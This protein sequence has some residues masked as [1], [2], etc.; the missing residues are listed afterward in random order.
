MA[1]IT[2]E[3]TI[4]WERKT[5]THYKN[6]GYPFTKIKD[7]FVVKVE[8]LM[9]NSIVQIEVQCDECGEIISTSWRNYKKNINRNIKYYCNKCAN[10]IFER[11]E[12][13]RQANFKKENSFET[14]CIEN[15]RRD[16][17]DR[18]DYELNN[19]KP[20]EISYGTNKKYYF[21]CHKILGH[22]SELKN[23]KGFI[24]GQEGSIQC[25]QCNSFAQ[26]LINLYGDNALNLYWDYDKNILNPWEISY[27]S[28]I[29]K[30]WL[31]CQEKDYHSYDILC[32]SFVAGNR[33]LYCASKKVHL[34]DSLGTLY[35]QVL[36][37][38][39]N[40]N[41]ISPYEYPP[42]SHQYVY[43]KC[44]EGKHEDYYRSIDSSNNHNFRCPECNNSKGEEM[45]SINLINKGFVKIS[46]EE[47][48]KLI[49]NNKYN[50]NYYIPQMK[51][52]G[53]VGLGNGLLSYDF[54]IPKL[55][56][57]IEYQGEMHERFIRGIHKSIKDFE[58]QQEHDRRKKEYAQIHNINLLEIWYW[59]FDKIEK[60]L[61]TKL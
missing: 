49:D 6:L 8:D 50:K 13:T 47:F 9:D 20:S 24:N 33:C 48:N 26:Y 28:N 59:D 14:W 3:V 58:K 56:H 21:K 53:L 60:I 34:L 51:Y 42:K 19:K 10:K 31:K 36:D 12:K 15:N 7:D 27:G 29:K 41:K 4:K 16:V 1:L 17:L 43:W 38:W 46:Q 25:N 54:Y 23:I 32:Y 5:C 22:H 18:W 45:I 2:K 55:N 52:D 39:S 40:K 30:V 11:N 61:D 35:P 37:I 44:P 57:L